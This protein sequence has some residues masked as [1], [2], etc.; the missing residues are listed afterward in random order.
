MRLVPLRRV[1]PPIQKEAKVAG[2]SLE[3]ASTAVD[4]ALERAREMGLKPMA[5][6]VLDDGGNLKALKR[7]DGAGILR[8]D[9]AFGKAW[10]ALGMGMG[11]RGIAGQ[12]T[13][14]PVFFGALASVAG[15]RLVPGPGGVLVRQG[16]DVIG[17]VGL[18]GDIPDADED[19]AVAGIQAAG[20]EADTG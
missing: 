17:A 19:C 3:Q 14:R 13:E 12:A 4:R 11:S 6:V 9:I 5:V 10:G 7:E 18:S 15:G 20:L 16:G 1:T 8:I 2:I